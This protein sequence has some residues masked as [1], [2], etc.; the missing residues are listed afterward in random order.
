MGNLI[1]A[2]E[3]VQRYAAEL[4]AAG[5]LPDRLRRIAEATLAL[6]EQSLGDPQA[7]APWA[8]HNLAVLVATGLTEE[9]TRG[10]TV[11]LFH[12]VRRRLADALVADP[13]DLAL[14]LALAR[15]AAELSG[16]GRVAADIVLVA[17]ALGRDAAGPQLVAAAV[18]L[19]VSGG[20]SKQNDV[21]AAARQVAAAARNAI[22]R[23]GGRL[24]HHP[25]LP[26]DLAA[27][28]LL[29]AEVAEGAERAGHL[30]SA[31]GHLG[32]HE[33]RFGTTTAARHL[34]GQVLALRA[35]AGGAP[36]DIRR[37]A[38]TLL[39]TGARERTLH[40]GEATRLVRAIERAGGMDAK[41]A[42]QLLP[43]VEAAA[44]DQREPWREVLGS[45]LQRTG[46]ES[47]LRELWEQTLLD[48]KKNAEAARGLA[49]MLIRNLRGGLAPPFDNAV[50]DKVLDNVPYTSMARWSASDVQAVLELVKTAF[51]VSRAATF[52]RERLL[53]TR[54]L[55]SKAGLWRI[56]V[57]LADASGDEAAT[58][59]TLRGAIRHANVPQ[60]RLRLATTLLDA[61]TGLQE[62][63]NVLRPLLDKKGDDGA[64]AHALKNRLDKHPQMRGERRS[65]LIRFEEQ[66]GVGSPKPFKLRVLHTTPDYVL[67]EAADHKAPE[68]YEHRHLRTMV[69]GNDIPGGV[70][71][72]ELRKGDIVHAPLR[73]QDAA[74]DRDGLRVYWV[75]DTAA[76]R[77]ELSPATLRTRLDDEERTFG[78]G[79]SN[80]LAMKVAWDG[81]RS[82]LTARIFAA[83]G[84][85]EFHAR[86][87]VVEEQL[88]EGV[89]PK[90]L[91]RGRRMW[92]L[93][94]RVYD[95]GNQH[96]R[97]YQ[98]IGKLSLTGPDGE[99]AGAKRKPKPKGKDRGT[100]DA[101]PAPEAATEPTSAPAPE[102]QEPKPAAAAEP[103]AEAAPEPKP[104][105]TEGPE[106]AAA[107]E[108]A[109]EAA[110]EPKPAETEQPAPAPPAEAKA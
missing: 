83:S 31:H 48:G 39:E 13:D 73:G 23:L 50:L 6:I 38:L 62:A 89:A 57:E 72:Y 55:K 24:P 16:D 80:P 51:G 102:V 66:I 44:G 4:P 101:M 9:A 93:V 90:K 49:Q 67:L 21:V 42:G 97:R 99:G 105:Q 61:G 79:E 8:D 92:G 100:A 71:T 107:P 68:G 74:G 19:A 70:K 88:P 82:R 56:A 104:V 37:D 86:A 25:D 46:D 103:T 60:A 5:L 14:A 108:P 59:E 53:A 98:V 52:T 22:E 91:G 106:P 94:G 27:L 87:V 10:A 15:G 3:A 58:L 36:E 32:D 17:R 43:L 77:L 95:E 7:V 65:G 109:V 40:A 18:S 78:I 81:R 69:R 35:R 29:D 28:E 85:G 64:Q 54:D 26:L 96:E 84:S 110:P 33:A 30:D 34:R 75:A 45:L 47:A 20:A 76:I 2:R 12:G 11:G 41:T 1:A 63:D